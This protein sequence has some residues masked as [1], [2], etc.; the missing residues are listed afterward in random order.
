MVQAFTA[1]GHRLTLITPSKC[2]LED[3]SDFYGVR[4]NFDIHYLRRLRL[5]EVGLLLWGYQAAA[6]LRQ[7]KPDL[8]YGRQ[9]HGCYFAALLGHRVILEIHEPPSSKLSRKLFRM[10]VAMPS[11]VRL[12]TNSDGLARILRNDFVV[13]SDKIIAAPNG[14]DD[15]GVVVAKHPNGDRVRIGYVG[16][17]YA[18]RG[19]EL[20]IALAR[21]CQ[22]AD[23]HLVG[24][25]DEDVS[26]WR[27]KSKDL[28]NVTFH[29][30]VPPAT[31][32][33]YRQDCD[34][35]LAPYPPQTLTKSM[36]DASEY[37]SPL[38]LFEYM[39][40]GR[41]IV[42]ANH[43]VLQE[44]VNDQT[45]FLCKPDNLEDWVRALQRLRDDREL[46]SRLGENARK[47]FLCDFTRTARAH[48][49][50]AGVTVDERIND[51][52]PVPGSAH[53]ADQHI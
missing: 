35:L 47:K 43:P 3:V 22:W 25:T 40:S 11:F 15:P 8:V 20:I 32:E 51:G 45:A 33:Q 36:R 9:L 30:F 38:K 1:I 41:A 12:V 2:D 18:G 13:S 23:F 26:Y 7:F 5:K 6:R 10:L 37:M 48:K 39:A 4:P 49:I 44:I 21:T 53:H 52:M 17:L 34:I 50:L 28:K 16:H 31:A 19:I 42:C 46:R 14:A 27:S 29:G 24:G